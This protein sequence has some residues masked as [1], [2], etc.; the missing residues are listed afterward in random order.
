MHKET[1]VNSAKSILLNSCSTIYVFQYENKYTTRVC[2]TAH[3]IH[4]LSMDTTFCRLIENKPNKPLLL[5]NII[6][7]I[8]VQ[9]MQYNT[10]NEVH[11]YTQRIN[12]IYRNMIEHHF[13]HE[14]TEQQDLAHLV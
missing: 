7:V 12:V 6:Y 14:C 2:S 3:V 11:I 4:R 5:C 10:S 13:I 9:S 8:T 1:I